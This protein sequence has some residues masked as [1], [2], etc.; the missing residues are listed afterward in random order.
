MELPHLRGIRR[1]IQYHPAPDYCLSP[2]FMAGV[3]EVGKRGLTFD[4][5][6]RNHQLASATELVRQCPEVSFVLDHIAKPGIAAGAREPWTRDLQR[7]ADLP[8]VVCKMAGVATE[9]DHTRW[10][11]DDLQPYMAHAIACFGL[12]RLL[13]A[14][15]WPVMNLAT[16]FGA[17]VS[18]LDQVIAGNS[19]AERRALFRDNAIRTYRLT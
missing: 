14:S 10:T 19:E 6:I 17:W 9:A 15:D 3:R 12:E 13:F 8:N 1:L 4:L 18:L 16:T 11:P 5:C 2:K 7:M